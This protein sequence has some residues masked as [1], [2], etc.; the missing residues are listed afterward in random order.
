M[1]QLTLFSTDISHSLRN[2]TK[3]TRKK[4]SQHQ[5]HGIHWDL[6]TQ[7]TEPEKEMALFF[8][9]IRNFTSLIEKRHAF[10]VIYLVKKLFSI[11]QTIIRIH[12]GQIIETSGDG[13]YAAF[14]MDR[15]ASEA[16]NAAVQAGMAILETLENLNAQSLEKNLRQRI[17]VGIGLH[18]GSV[19]IDN[20]R[21][22][23][24]DHV[25]VMGYAVNIASRIQ[26]A[27][28]ELNNNFIVSSAVFNLLRNPSPKYAV[29]N[30]NLKGI[31][32]RLEL[33]LMG[34]PYTTW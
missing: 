8:L 17:D 15:D 34:K 18:V 33:Y 25:V 26:A 4:T 10:D 9:D 24:K 14:G 12:H 13:F 27:T 32:E 2:H 7:P 20:L 16:V 19:A 29:A 5:R 1:Q 22:G 3:K 6:W 23:S 31:T 28:K 30:V 21:L 11:F